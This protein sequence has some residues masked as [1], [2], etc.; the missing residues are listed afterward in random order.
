MHLMHLTQKLELINTECHVLLL[1]V[2]DYSKITMVQCLDE[3][4]SIVAAKVV[5]KYG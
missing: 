5:A 1:V 2:R 3:N 4:V